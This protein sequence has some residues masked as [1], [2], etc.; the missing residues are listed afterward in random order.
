MVHQLCRA[1]G[2]FWSWGCK[3]RGVGVEA[4]RCVSGVLSLQ[5]RASGEAYGPNSKPQTIKALPRS[6]V[7][8]VSWFSYY[9]NLNSVP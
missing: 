8:K 4:T 6:R 3:V 2:C 7:T 1:I 9:G 5:G